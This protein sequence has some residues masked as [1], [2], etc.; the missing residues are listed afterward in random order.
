MK[1]PV[2]SLTGYG[3]R[4]PESV[5]FPESPASP[6]ATIAPQ[7]SGERRPSLSRR[8]DPSPPPRRYLKW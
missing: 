6:L 2:W 8:S 5:G 4:F 3:D 7:S 1:A